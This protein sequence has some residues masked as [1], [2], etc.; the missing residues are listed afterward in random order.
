M[1]VKTTFALFCLTVF[2]FGCAPIAQTATETPVL[3]TATTTST[4]T[5]TATATATETATP[6]ATEAPAYNICPPLDSDPRGCTLSSPD[7]L[8][9]PNSGFSEHL[10]SLRKPFSADTK[11]LS[12]ILPTIT[13]NPS[14]EKIITFVDAS[15]YLSDSG[16]D[17]NLPIRLL[18]TSAYLEMNINNVSYAWFNYNYELQNPDDPT[19]K[20]ANII[21]KGI[22]PVKGPNISPI[23]DNINNVDRMVKMAPD[24]IKARPVMGF[25]V[26]KK[27]I[28]GGNLDPLEELAYQKYP[29]MDQAFKDFIGEKDPVTGTIVPSN[30]N[31]LRDML[32]VLNISR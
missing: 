16:S 12:A 15:T 11:K 10:R 4:E 5:A 32:V 14:S 26:G 27:D 29:N 21:I 17:S 20:D 24:F 6:T 1:K 23:I 8:L 13:S 30:V 7:E 28:E 2:L 18:G 3:P 31:A 9:D 22:Y 19:N 25:A